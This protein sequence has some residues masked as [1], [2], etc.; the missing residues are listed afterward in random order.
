M[1]RLMNHQASSLATNIKRS[2]VPKLAWLL[3]PRNLATCVSYVP[4]VINRKMVESVLNRVLHEQIA[5]GDFDYLS[6]QWLV[7]EL[8]DAQLFVTIGF[9]QGHFVCREVTTTAVEADAHLSVLTVDA[10]DLMQQKIDPD[11]LFFQRRLT[12]S[13]NTEL[14]HHVKNTLDTLDSNAIP[15]LILAV[16]QNYQA[17]ISRPASLNQ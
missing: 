7:I 3:A 11:T 5:D 1:Q 4:S 10:I 13:G 2:V 9:A 8:R 16:L 6:G 17:I 15:K 12:I 14:A